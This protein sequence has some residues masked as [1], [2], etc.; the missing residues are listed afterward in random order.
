MGS[1]FKNGLLLMLVILAGTTRE[2]VVPSASAIEHDLDSMAGEVEHLIMPTVLPGPRKRDLIE[3][4]YESIPIT[5]QP[6]TL[7]PSCTKL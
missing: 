5:M 1:L 3:T 7:T 4:V 6:I 2:A